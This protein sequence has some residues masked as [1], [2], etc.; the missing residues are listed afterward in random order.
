MTHLLFT[1]NF[2]EISKATLD[3]EKSI[4]KIKV[5]GNPLVALF[6]LIKFKP[7]DPHTNSPDRFP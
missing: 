2:Y 5:N 6:F 7:Q 3:Y 1:K 4:S